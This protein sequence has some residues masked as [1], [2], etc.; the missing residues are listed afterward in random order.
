MVGL[1]AGIGGFER[2]FASS[3]YRPVLLVESAAP[4]LAVLKAKFPD[5]SEFARDIATLDQLPAAD[6]VAAGFPCTDLSPAGGMA[7]IAGGESG[8]V[9]HVFRLLRDSVEVRWL[10]LENVPF[11]LQLNRGAAIQFLVE[12]LETL[13]FRWAYRVIDTRAFGVPQRRRRVFLLASR[14][15]DPAPALLGRDAEP[16][17]KPDV[18]SLGGFYWTEG[19]R[20]VGWVREGIP[21]LKGSSG[22]GIPS[23]PA[24]WDRTTGHFMTPSIESA[25]RLQG[26]PA[27]WTAAA[28]GHGKRWKLVGNAVSVPVS[29]WIASQ[30]SRPTSERDP[31]AKRRPL[32]EGDKWPVAATGSKEARFRVEVGEWPVRYK[33]RPLRTFLRNGGSPLSLKAARGF[34]HRARASRL[35]FEEGFLGS[36]DAYV[37]DRAETPHAADATTAR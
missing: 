32:R 33:Q 21:P 29:R 11:M 31:G 14:E 20:G 15:D 19:N 28:G 17:P 7:G 6:V 4:A 37:R 1:F 12:S 5:V 27:G 34:L 25:E 8:L 35:H 10:L 2:G 30:L 22:L 16:A 24:I 23:P 18:W 26:F 9:S 13:G 36:L 3:G